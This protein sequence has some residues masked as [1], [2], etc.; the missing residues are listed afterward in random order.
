MGHQLIRQMVE[1]VERVSVELAVILE[2]GL[3]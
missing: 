1:A 3:T 2:V